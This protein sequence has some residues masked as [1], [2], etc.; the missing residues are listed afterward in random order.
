MSF[1]IFGF[2]CI[3]D[4]KAYSVW[5]IRFKFWNKDIDRALFAASWSK[6]YGTYFNFMFIHV[7][8][9]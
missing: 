6:E 3:P 9:D 2:D 5:F 8:G 7:I 4:D 1:H